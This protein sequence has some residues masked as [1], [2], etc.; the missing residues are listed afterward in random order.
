MN[1][2]ETEKNKWKKLENSIWKHDIG[3]LNFLI[4]TTFTIFATFENLL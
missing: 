3:F 1:T 4:I 2:E